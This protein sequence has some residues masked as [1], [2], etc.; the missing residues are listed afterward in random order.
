MSAGFDA[1][2]KVLAN[3]PSTGSF[4]EGDTPTVADC[5]LVPQVYNALRFKLPMKA[6]PT[7]KRIHDE[8]CEMEEF[9]LAHPSAQPDAE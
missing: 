4:C 8:C 1:L 9:K 6:Y 5:C 3:N 2:E 7:I